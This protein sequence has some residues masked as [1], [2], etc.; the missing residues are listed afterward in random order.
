[1]RQPSSVSM[2]P[3]TMLP[4]PTAS[5]AIFLA[6]SDLILAIVINSDFLVVLLAFVLQVSLNVP[7]AAETANGADT[8]SARSMPFIFVLLGDLGYSGHLE[9]HKALK[10]CAGRP[11][12]A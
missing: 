2:P 12:M 10:V 8:S 5:I 1:M 3:F 7:V 9:N 11:L 6:S 4:P